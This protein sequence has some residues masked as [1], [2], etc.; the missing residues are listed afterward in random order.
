MFSV[1]QKVYLKPV[2]KCRDTFRLCILGGMEALFGQFVAISQ[3]SPEG[4]SG[5]YKIEEDGGYY[6]Y[7]ESWFE[8]KQRSE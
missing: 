2:G 6:F 5:A 7:E 3:I 1:G 4:Y 8:Y